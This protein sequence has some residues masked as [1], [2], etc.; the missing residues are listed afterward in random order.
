MSDLTIELA[1]VLFFC[2]LFC[3]S[4]FE[5][6]RN[7]EDYINIVGQFNI[8]GIGYQKH[9]VWVL[10]TGEGLAALSLIISTKYP[11]FCSLAV[12]ILLLY[13]SVIAANLLQNR[14]DLKCGCSGAAKQQTISNIHLWRL[15][16]LISMLLLVAIPAATRVLNWLDIFT[17]LSSS[18]I[19][20]MFYLAS[21]LLIEN[22]YK[23]RKLRN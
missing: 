12:A 6:Y 5:K 23:L 1:I 17:V 14:S 9:W 13:F 15:A 7:I 2:W 8:P 21:D 20:V 18:V 11:V 19:L 3:S 4:A 10:I 16:I 22:D